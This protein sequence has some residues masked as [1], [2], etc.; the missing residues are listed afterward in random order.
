MVQGSI[1]PEQDEPQ[2]SSGVLEMRFRSGHDVAHL[3]ELPLIGF[4]AEVRDI[5]NQLVTPELD[6]TP[7]VF[8]LHMT[9]L[10]RR[11]YKASLS[12]RLLNAAKALSSMELFTS[13]EIQAVNG[14]DI[15]LKCKFSSSAPI[16]EDVTV[17]WTFRPLA[18]GSEES[19][20]YYHREP[21]P[22]HEGRF[23]GRAVWDGNI[24]RGDGSIIIRNIQQ[25]YNGTY[26]CQVKNPPD[27]HGEM[28]EIILQVVDKVKFSEIMLL[29]LVI[30]VGSVVIIIIVLA[31]VLFRYY[32]KQKTHSTTMSVMECREKLTE[33]PLNLTD[34]NA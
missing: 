4:W 10:S 24:K 14:T 32:R 9:S 23:V 30:A 2:Y 13:E 34:A 22:P 5:I 19:V 11:N 31:V 6:L 16:G 20:F 15:R 1:R 25:T 17:S 12:I 21:Y 28:G 33:K 18:G 7:E 26:L 8:L 3:L 29:L 27:V